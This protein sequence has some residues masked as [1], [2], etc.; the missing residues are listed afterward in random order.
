METASA[1]PLATQANDS[2][3]SRWTVTEAGRAAVREMR[4][5]GVNQA[6]IA[7]ALGMSASTL[8][9]CIERDEALKQAYDAGSGEMESELVGILMGQARK[10][11]TTAAIFLLKGACGFRENTPVAPKSDTPAINITIPPAMSAA[12]LAALT[13]Q[14]RVVSSDAT[15]DSTKTSKRKE[16][17]R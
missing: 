14:M 16:I 17:V 8:R 4:S 1:N 13:A 6:V 9:D 5:N 12:D 2:P 11:N 10:G 15:D 3:K 7:S